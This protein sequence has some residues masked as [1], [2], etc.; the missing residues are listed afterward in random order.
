MRFVCDI[1]YGSSGTTDKEVG[2]NNAEKRDC[3][4]QNG[5]SYRGS[6]FKIG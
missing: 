2:E 5:Y 1:I 3:R 4:N 6:Y